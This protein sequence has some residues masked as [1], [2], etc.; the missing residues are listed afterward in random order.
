MTATQRGQIHMDSITCSQ[1]GNWGPFLDL[2]EALASCSPTLDPRSG[3]GLDLLDD[4]I[5]RTPA[6]WV[7]EWSFTG[8]VSWLSWMLRTDQ[9]HLACH[10]PATCC[11]QL[12][13]PGSTWRLLLSLACCLC[14]EWGGERGH[15]EDRNQ[16]IALLMESPSLS[17]AVARRG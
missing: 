12:G 5:T 14:L 10:S 8:N 7:L 2:S 15:S 17:G 13:G 3:A 6:M 1:T 16:P 11:K 4:A 9:A